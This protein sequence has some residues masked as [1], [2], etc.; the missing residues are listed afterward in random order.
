MYDPALDNSNLTCLGIS[1]SGKTMFAQSFALKH[2]ARGGRVIVLDRSTG[3]WDD[4]VAA[5]PGAV[6]HRVLLDSGFRI[7]PWELPR[8][9]GEPSQTKFEYLL[10]LHTL[11]VGELHGGMPA[12]TAQERAVLE[13]ACRAVFRSRAGEHRAHRDL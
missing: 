10:D 8:H 4:L 5:V 7:N 9:A 12:L 2:I 3:H 1:G 13:G 11:M 6:V